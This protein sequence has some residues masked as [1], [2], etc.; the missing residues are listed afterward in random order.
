MGRSRMA[1]RFPKGKAR[2]PAVMERVARLLIPPAAREEVVGDL[3]ERYRSPLSYASEA[4]SVMPFLVASQIRRNTNVPALAIAAFVFFVFCFGG[5][6]AIDAPT[7]VP[8]W[9]RAAVPT[10]A[11]L[12]GLVLRDAYRRNEVQPARR[13]A[14]D[15]LP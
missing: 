1:H 6:A 13:A 2:P 12:I 4:L 8:R 5:I 15:I 7:D 10:V 9:L 14:F 3:W 11:A